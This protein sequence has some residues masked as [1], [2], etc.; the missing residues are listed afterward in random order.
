MI[1]DSQIVPHAVDRRHVHMDSHKGHIVHSAILV[2]VD[3]ALVQVR[4]PSKITIQRKGHGHIGAERLRVE[5]A[6]HALQSRKV[7]RVGDYEA[8][9]NE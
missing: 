4:S 5:Y 3:C 6:N 7:I 8:W 1:L 2:E 9:L